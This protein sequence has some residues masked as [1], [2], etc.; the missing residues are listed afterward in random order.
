LGIFDCH[1]FSVTHSV[2]GFAPFDF[3]FL[4]EWSF[5]GLFVHGRYCTLSFDFKGWKC[6]G[7]LP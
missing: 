3:D 7:V 2:P 6:G 5:S 4:L 1:F